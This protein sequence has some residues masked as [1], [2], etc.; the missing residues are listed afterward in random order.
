MLRCI[1]IF[2]IA[3]PMFS[4]AANSA[5]TPEPKFQLEGVG[6]TETVVFISGLAY[7]LTYAAARIEHDK[8]KNFFCLPAGKYVDSKLLLDL[9]NRRLT[10]VQSAESI[11]T[12]TIVELGE[13]FPCK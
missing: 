6:Y 7:G 11:T 8:G 4:A 3:T 13:R 9:L 12:I 5:W 10:G 2:L 1:F